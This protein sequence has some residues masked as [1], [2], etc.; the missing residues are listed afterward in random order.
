MNNNTINNNFFSI[1]NSH[2]LQSQPQPQPQP[3]PQHQPQPQ[4]SSEIQTTPQNAIIE[5]QSSEVVSNS[6]II[7]DEVNIQLS[8]PIF[9]GFNVKF[10]LE[11]FKTFIKNCISP[12]E[13]I[14]YICNEM[15]TFFKKH[16]L[17]G[18][19]DLVDEEK[20]NLGFCVH[21]DL[22]N[23]LFFFIR[24][25]EGNIYDHNILLLLKSINSTIYIC[26]DPQH[27]C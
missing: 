25:N 11:D 10:T 8:H 2:S 16:N 20:N 19:V 17:L 22:I 1:M 23:F 13:F 12:R 5:E 26:N 21:Y 18:L 15:K 24:Q 9:W 4:Q 27:T 6:E 7:I 3:Q 14:N